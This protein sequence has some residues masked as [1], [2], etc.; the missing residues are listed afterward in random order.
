VKLRRKGLALLYYL[1]VEGPTRRERLADVLWGH[2]GALQNLR[3]ELHRLKASLGPLGLEPFEGSGDPLSLSGIRL[4]RNTVT[5]TVMDGLDDISPE[6]QEWLERQRSL[7]TGPEGHHPRAS[8]AAELARTITA[9]FVLVLAGEPGS[10]RRLVARDLASALGLPLIEGC[11]GSGPAVHY[12]V[13]ADPSCGDVAATIEADDRSVWVLHRSL[14]GEDDDLILRLRATVPPERMRFVTLEPLTWW[15]AKQILPDGMTFVERARLYLASGGNLRYLS[16]LLKLRSMVGPGMP[17][18]VP[19][20]VRAAFALEAR[21]L[22][23]GARRSLERASIRNGTL[24]LPLLEALGASDHL[25]ELERS[26]WLTFHDSGWRFTSELGRRMLDGQVRE[27]TKR[28]LHHEV[29]VALE[30]QGSLSSAAYHRERSAGA[31]PVASSNRPLVGPAR[32][33]IVAHVGVGREQWLDEAEVDAP[34]VRTGGDRVTFSR[35]AS[36][37]PASRVR[38]RLDGEAL[39]LRIRGRAY[40]ED[41]QPSDHGG[42]EP[43]LVLSLS[44]SSARE[45]HFG[46]ARTVRLGDAGNVILPLEQ[47]F[48]VWLLAPAARTLTLENRGAGAVIEMKVNAYRPVAAGDGTDPSLAVVEAYS[49]DKDAHTGPGDVDPVDRGLEGESKPAIVRVWS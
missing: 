20:S 19:L 16:E 27:G 7:D 24:S 35:T 34:S 48:D 17:L 28:R 10:G 23:E 25:D 4:E 49:L 45:A 12:V 13:A 18:P 47:R 1:A 31:W 43:V 42:G 5:G 39:L 15:D 41:H 6:Y 21:K 2:R 8:L 3:V 29:A 22:S 33:P 26:G 40:I 9:P 36:S 38:F 32:P 44:G 30:K 46:D 11:G 37:S 14:F